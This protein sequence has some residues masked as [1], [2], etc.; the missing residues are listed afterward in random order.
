M[1]IF[2][3]KSSVSPIASFFSFGGDWIVGEL[4][5]EIVLFMYNLFMSLELPITNILD[6]TAQVISLG[7][8]NRHHC[9][10]MIM[11]Y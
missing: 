11:A 10:R 7:R 1:Y 3:D 9:K 6:D 4:K 8:H 2:L 5:Q